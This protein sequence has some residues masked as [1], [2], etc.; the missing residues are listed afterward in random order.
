[1]AIRDNVH[2]EADLLATAI[3]HSSA[4]PDHAP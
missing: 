3:V 2:R 4:S 1:V